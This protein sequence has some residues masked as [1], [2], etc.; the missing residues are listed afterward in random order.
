MSNLIINEHTSSS[1]APRTYYNAHSADLT[2]ALAL[3]FNTAGERLTKKAASSKLYYPIQLCKDLDVLQESRKLYIF[4]KKNNVKTLNIAGNGI[5]TL[6]KFCSQEY[7]NKVLFDLLLPLY[8]HLGIEKI[9]NGGQ[10]GVD[11][12]GSVVAV[13][14]DIDC[15]STLPKGFK[16]RF[17]DGKDVYMSRDWVENEIRTHVSML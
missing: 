4:M 17:E 16:M 13:K 1:Y 10:S 3:D 2:I 7:I 12:A 15:E 11:F 5:Y 8:T 6:Q 9:Y 14:L